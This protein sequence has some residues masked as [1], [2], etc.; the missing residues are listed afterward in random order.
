MRAP[1]ENT[2]EIQALRERLITA[3]IQ[4]GEHRE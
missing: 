3:L 2:P 1:L 4:T